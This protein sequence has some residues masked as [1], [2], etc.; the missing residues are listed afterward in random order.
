M[1]KY[2]FKKLFQSKL[3]VI[4]FALLLLLNIGLCY[5]SAKETAGSVTIEPEILEQLD[6]YNRDADA[7]NSEYARL[8]KGNEEYERVSREAFEQAYAEYKKE[9]PNATSFSYNFPAEEYFDSAFLADIDKYRDCYMAYR[10]LQELDSYE[11]DVGRVVR[12]AR[13][14]QEDYL[15]S[16]VSEQAYEYRYQGDLIRIYEVNAL[17]EIEYEYAVGWDSYFAYTDG[18]VLM[19]I[20]LTV[21]AVGLCIGEYRSGMLPILHATKGGRMRTLLCKLGV[22]LCVSAGLVLIFQAAALIVFGSLCGLSSMGNFVQVF[23]AYKFC[24]EIITVG[25]YLALSLGIKT[26]TLFALGACIMLL[27]TLCKDYAL[28]FVSSLGVLAAQFALYFFVS[29]EQFG[30]YHMLNIFGAMDTHSYFTR[31]YSLNV[32]GASVAFIPLLIT[33]YA[34]VALTLAMAAGWMFCKTPGAGRKRKGIKL[35]LPATAVPLIGRTLIGAELHKLLVGNKLAVILAVLLIAKLLISSGTYVYQSS[36]T[37]SVYHEYMTTLAGE[38][39]EEKLQYIKEE[40]ERIDEAGSDAKFSQMMEA[41]QSGKI[42]SEE[43]AQYF[44][45]YEYAQERTEHLKRIEGRRD[46]LQGLAEQGKEG[47]FVY[48]TGWNAL[49]D[50]EFDFLL[51]ALVLLS[52]AGVFADEYRAGAYQ[53]LRPSKR[54][55]A[56]VLFAKYAAAALLAL[57]VFAAFAAIDLGFVLLRF[58]LPMWT[59]PIQSLPGFAALPDMTIAQGLIAWLAVKGAAYLLMAMMLLCLSLVTKSVLGTSI[60][61]AMVTLLPYFMRRFGMEAASGIDYT[62]LLDGT[63]FLQSFAQDTHYMTYLVILAAVIC[64]LT[65]CALIKWLDLWPR[66]RKS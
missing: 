29:V 6:A 31:Y 66:K 5:R 3:F 2:E 16:G 52:F 21:A 39:T 50:G 44:N 40:R 30:S 4:L 9:N 18:N 41:H 32:F 61:V 24:P 36:F 49:F 37:D 10:V 62:Y 56:G 8:G 47:H 57:G 54:G 65:L 7:W 25:E 42:T 34:L 33:V 59:A 53:I 11:A 14:A 45:E 43:Y 58:E 48:D 20:L 60:T 17:I 51:Y 1:L 63:T 13:M 19:A 12:A 55:R 35:R 28:T 46:Y 38:V 22:L 27:G 64:V 26:L 23:E 15:A